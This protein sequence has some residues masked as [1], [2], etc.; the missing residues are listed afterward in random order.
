MRNAGPIDSPTDPF[1]SV[2]LPT[3]GKSRKPR[4][5]G[6]PP[7]VSR[8]IFGPQG[9]HDP[10]P[11]GQEPETGKAALPP[12][13]PQ[14]QPWPVSEEAGPASRR[15]EPRMGELID[16]DPPR[17]RRLLP[18]L[19]VLVLITVLM[20]Y[21]VPA[22]LMSGSVLHGTRVGGVDI[23]G[24]TVTQ[25]AEKLR[26]QLAARL[27][28]PVVVTIGTH[29]DTVQPDEAGLELDVVTTINQVPSGFPS[30]VEVWRSLTGATDIEPRITV[31]ASQ[32]TRTVEA[33]AKAVDK[34]PHEGR[35]AFKG[36]RPVATRP[37]EGALL[38]RTEAVRA[39]SQAFLTGGGT[40]TLA[41]KPAR[42]ATEPQAVEKAVTQ[43]ERAVAG[44]IT[45][46]LGGKQAQLTPA[47]IAANLT[48]V[49]DGEGAL[50]P[51]FDT[52]AALAPIEGALVGAAQAPRDATYEIVDG[53][54]R[55]VPSRQGRG[56]D[57][58]ELTRDLGRLLRQ[59]GERVI[60]VGLAAAPPDVTTDEV[61][62]LGI[63]ETV[64]TFTSLFDCCQ[65]RVTNI[66][67]MAAD[68]DGRLV[69]PGETFSLNEA[70]GE[71]TAEGGYVPAPQIVGGRQLT[72]MGGGAS[73]F[74]T[75]L[76][77]AVFFGGF[78]EVERTPM[79]YHSVRYPPG[80]DVALLYPDLDL[81]WRNDS[82]FGV[83]IKTSST[84]TSVTV[85]LW[86]TKRYDRIEAVESAK[87]DFTPFRT[88]VSDAPDCR[89]VPGQQGFTIDVTRV[90]HDDG[91]EIKRDKKVTTKY[92]PQA[93]VICTAAG[94]TG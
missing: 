45:L 18:A 73:Q 83:L 2:P 78:E 65:P 49:P 82:D 91:D 77:N 46:R 81:K 92:R 43:A 15:P 72:I 80:R 54:P 71:R 44:P 4:I 55:L 5:E 36:L 3:R 37:R 10:S 32:L 57:G 90:F 48:F 19:G 8:D 39:I 47:M 40:A 74:A 60:P 16:P 94:G 20:A 68:L 31:D 50:K 89:P 70:V 25:A 52:E 7:G 28:K 30:P 66:R 38:D 58:E 27:R 26:T 33:L 41:L 61:T 51:D 1:A 53:R 84:A 87:R 12:M 76:Y 59:G 93:Q 75:A 79:D 88:V 67:Q 62:G 6:L 9:V 42:P 69:R 85:T 22:V 14:S 34:P 21:L 29:R 17:R 11:A 24:L 64:S 86:S 63:K 13:T 35:V 56:V 23:G